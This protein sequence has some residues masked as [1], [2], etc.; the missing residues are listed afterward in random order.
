MRLSRAPSSELSAAAVVA[1]AD[2]G[3]A[4]G[5][6]DFVVIALPRGSALDAAPRLLA[7]ADAAAARFVG[8]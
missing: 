4:S 5:G 6:A 2:A 1:Q 3:L 8:S 7:E